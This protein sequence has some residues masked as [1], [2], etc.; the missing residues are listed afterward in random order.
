MINAAPSD[1]IFVSGGT[2]A[3][4]LTFHS[5][6]KHYNECKKIADNKNI[7]IESIPHIIISKI[8]HD[9]VKLIADEY[10]KEKLAGKIFSNLKKMN[11]NLKCFFFQIEI[12]EIEVNS[13]GC[14]DVE[15]VISS[16]KPN[17][18]LISIMLANNETGVIQVCIY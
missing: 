18:I 3:N 11:S 12:T 15:N 6:L 8:E 14:V 17:T 4:N 9:S 16:I 10:K 7:K 13:H 5:A 1:I 2:E